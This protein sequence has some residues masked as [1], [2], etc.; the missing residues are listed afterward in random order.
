MIECLALSDEGEVL[1]SIEVETA[2]Y[3]ILNNEHD[4]IY[5]SSN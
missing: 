1:A 2:K 5:V 3:Y 4:V